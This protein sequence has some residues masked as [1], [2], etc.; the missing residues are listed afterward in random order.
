MYVSRTLYSSVIYRRGIICLIC[1]YLESEYFKVFNFP[2]CGDFFVS[3][4]GNEFKNQFAYLVY[5]LFRYQEIFQFFFLLTEILLINWERS[6]RAC[7][8]NCSK[9]RTLAD[10]KLRCTT[11]SDGGTTIWNERWPEEVPSNRWRTYT[12][13]Y[14]KN[15]M[16]WRTKCLGAKKVRPQ[17]RHLKTILEDGSKN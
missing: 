14:R 16:I 10:C 12:T 3:P 11:T 7:V 2:F 5:L 8:R 15:T 17:A 9:T 13:T 4:A 6:F 1:L